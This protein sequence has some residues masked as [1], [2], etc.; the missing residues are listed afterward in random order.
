MGMRGPKRVDKVGHVYG[1]Y[2]VIEEFKDPNNTSNRHYYLVCECTNCHNIRKI[3]D[4]N[5]SPNIV[6]KVCLWEKN[7]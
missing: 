1:D 3:R 4:D 7:E 5:L 2:K 6:C